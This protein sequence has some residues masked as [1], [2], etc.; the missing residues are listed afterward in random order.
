MFLGLLKS[1]FLKVRTKVLSFDAK[2]Y[3]VVTEGSVAMARMA[4][5]LVV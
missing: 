5:V 1:Q 3:M 2:G 4:I